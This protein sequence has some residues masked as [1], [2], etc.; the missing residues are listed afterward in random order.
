MKH[1]REIKIGLVSV[2]ALFLLYYGLNFLKGIDIFSPVKH[3][4]GT[5]ADLGGLNE[6]APVFI[7]G[8]KVGQ[9][10]KVQYDF[11]SSTPFVVALSIN[12]DID[13]PLGSR[14]E[15]FDDGLLGGK[16]V[17]I[18]LPD[19]A[20][21]SRIHLGN[22]TLPTSV[23]HGL[24][25]SLQEELMPKIS[26]AIEHVDTLVVSANNLIASDDLKQ[27]L[28]NVKVITAELKASSIKLKSLMNNDVPVIVAD[29]KGTM[30]DVRLFAGKL[31]DLDLALTISKVNST[32]DKVSHFADKLNSTDGTVGMLMND[33]QLYLNINQTVADADKLI[34]DLKQNPKRYVHF[35]L[36]GNSR[37][38]KKQDKASA[39]GN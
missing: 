31:N 1:S 3:Y 25:A 39:A 28:G 11:R 36:F 21:Y 34:V 35:S 6:S 13:L 10:D 26:T 12:K 5:Y 22:D 2:I 23:S 20:D 15:L 16:A 9:V 14:I 37:E 29:V 27:S 4:Y 38:R 33:K 8:F 17:Q 32:I 7:K 19:S 24:V 30:A 18:V